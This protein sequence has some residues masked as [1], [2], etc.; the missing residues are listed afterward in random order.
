MY[1]RQER[2]TAVQLAKVVGP[3]EAARR[4]HVASSCIRYWKKKD[5]LFGDV[6]DRRNPYDYQRTMKEEDQ[7]LSR[8]FV[9]SVQA[10]QRTK[11]IGFNN[12]E[13]EVRK[14]KILFTIP[15]KYPLATRI[16]N[17]LIAFDH[18]DGMSVKI[19]VS[20]DLFSFKMNRQHPLAKTIKD[21]VIK[22]AMGEETA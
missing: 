21:N 16:Y 4:L 17:F 14:N 13:I 9:T 11:T 20:A 15:A 3:K 22:C 18:P 5:E 7:N 19:K 10:D 12:M 1:N 2:E 8:P 6:M